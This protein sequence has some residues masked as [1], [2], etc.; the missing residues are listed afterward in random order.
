MIVQ[1]M[2]TICPYRVGDYLHT[3]N[4]THPTT[5]WPGTSWVQVQGRMLMGASDT[6]PVGSE[7]GEAEHTLTVPEIPA[8]SHKVYMGYSRG[9]LG[10]SW[11]RVDTN[12]PKSHGRELFPLV[13]VSP[14]TTCPR[15]V[16]R[17]S[18]GGRPDHRKGVG[19]MIATN[20]ILYDAPM[21][22]AMCSS[23]QALRS[24][25]SAGRGQAGRRSRTFSR[26]PRVT[27]TP[28]EAKG[29]KQ[30]TR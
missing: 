1:N 16:L 2:A 24:L 10:S 3:E 30:S 22:W 4:P 14:T 5:S 29:V 21:M 18:G 26:W 7:G 23:P 6:Y 15:T 9:S 13:G 12:S 11:A 17:I 25:L 20:P 28:Q 8:H 19:R 27:H